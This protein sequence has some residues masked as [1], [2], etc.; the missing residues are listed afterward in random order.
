MRVVWGL[1][2]EIDTGHNQYIAGTPDTMP[3]VYDAMLPLEIPGRR[4]KQSPEETLAD[5]QAGRPQVVFSHMLVLAT[6]VSNKRSTM[7]LF[8]RHKVIV[9]PW[10]RHVINA[11]IACNVVTMA[12]LDYKAMAEGRYNTQNHI[13]GLF[14]VSSGAGRNSTSKDPRR[15][16]RRCP[17]GRA[18]QLPPTAV[19]CVWKKRTR[20]PKRRHGTI[21]PTDRPSRHLPV[22]RGRVRWPVAGRGRGGVVWHW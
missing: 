20:R 19:H 22:G 1:R 11:I 5:D 6:G 17:P 18:S 8:V 15:V 10:F 2:L 12:G 16:L 9:H 21:D 13:L 4:A 14:E 7:Q 3:T